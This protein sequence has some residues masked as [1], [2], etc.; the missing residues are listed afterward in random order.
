M[1]MQSLKNIGQKL[2]RLESENEAL[3]DGRMDTQT[4]RRVLYK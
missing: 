2:L 1:S 3:T 4:V